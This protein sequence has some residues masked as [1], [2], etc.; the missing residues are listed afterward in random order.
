MYSIQT[1][2]LKSGKEIQVDFSSLDSILA[3]KEY[4]HEM[5]EIQESLITHLQQLQK[6]SKPIDLWKTRQPQIPSLRFTHNSTGYDDDEILI[7]IWIWKTVKIARIGIS[8]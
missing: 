1:F 2:V 5:T 4:A 7:Y 6:L 8:N 3:H